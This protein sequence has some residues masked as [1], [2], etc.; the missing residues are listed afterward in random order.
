[1]EGIPGA[2]KTALLSR[3]RHAF[4]DAIIVPELVEPATAEPDL[5]F[6]VA[7]DR[8]KEQ[9]VSGGRSALLDRYWPSTAAYVLADERRRGRNPT[10]GEIVRGLFGE[11]PAEPN[12]YVFLDSPWALAQAHAH[13]W[14]FGDPEFRHA[15][16]LAYFDLFACSAAPVLLLGAPDVAPQSLISFIASHI[17]PSVHKG[18]W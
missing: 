7:N 12:G 14:Q 4:P 9:I 16:R 17:G 3:L 11:P 8:R 6:F 15:L 10:P 13:D 5:D 18:S 1:V 2:G